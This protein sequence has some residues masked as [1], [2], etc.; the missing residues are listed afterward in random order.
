M[1]ARAGQSY[2]RRYAGSQTYNKF[3]RRHFRP[4][5]DSII[6]V[7]PSYTVAFFVP[8]MSYSGEMSS[9]DF[10]LIDREWITAIRKRAAQKGGSLYDGRAHRAE[11]LRSS[12]RLAMSDTTANHQPDVPFV[13]SVTHNA[14]ILLVFISNYV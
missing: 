6:C 4:D 1:F 11:W 3:R 14:A 2:N 5:P 9:D 12:G 13:C 8:A 10:Q 7:P